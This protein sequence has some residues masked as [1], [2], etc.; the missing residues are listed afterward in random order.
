MRKA[1]E[2]TLLTAIV[3]YKCV[4][5]FGKAL[6]T[7]SLKDRRAIVN[8]LINRNWITSDMQL[9]EIGNNIVKSNINLCQY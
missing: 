5:Y 6:R 1:S 7:F 3:N 8:E 2:Q 4:G 9:T